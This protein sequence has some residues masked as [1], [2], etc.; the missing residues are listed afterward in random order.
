MIMLIC[1]DNSFSGINPT[2][3]I[4]QSQGINISVSFTGSIDSST[5]ATV[6]PS[7]RFFPLIF[8]THTLNQYVPLF[9]SGKVAHFRGLLN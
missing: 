1:F 4:R 6:T 3:K 8:V 7:T 9:E 2:A 5:F